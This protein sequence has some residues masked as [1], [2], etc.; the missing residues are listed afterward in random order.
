MIHSRRVYSRHIEIEKGLLSLVIL[1]LEQ[2][3]S[4]ACVMVVRP[5]H[6]QPKATLSCHV[7]TIEHSLNSGVCFLLQYDLSIAYCKL[8]LLQLQKDAEELA[9][10]LLTDQR[11]ESLHSDSTR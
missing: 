1:I 2:H 10:H 11:T 9:A 5:L 3:G 6:R 4:A 8:P 7:E